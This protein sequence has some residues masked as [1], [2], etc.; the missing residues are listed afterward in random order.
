MKAL[1]KNTG[2]IL[3]VKSIWYESEPMYV[4]YTFNIK[5]SSF[6][7]LGKTGAKDESKNNLYLKKI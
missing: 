7:K 1:I 2:E 4:E 3:D 5:N 6:K